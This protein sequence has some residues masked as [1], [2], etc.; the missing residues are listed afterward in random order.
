MA[1]QRLKSTNTELKDSWTL[2]KIIIY[3]C[4]VSGKCKWCFRILYSICHLQRD[5]RICSLY[6]KNCIKVVWETFGL[7]YL[8][9]GWKYIIFNVISLLKFFKLYYFLPQNAFIKVLERW[10]IVKAAVDFK[11]IH[12]PFKLVTML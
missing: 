9:C 3:L 5:K 7:R 11:H 6:F 2:R 4:Q 1:C 10:K 8:K 12:V